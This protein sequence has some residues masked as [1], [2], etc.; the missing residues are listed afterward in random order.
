MTGSFSDLMSIVMNSPAAAVHHHRRLPFTTSPEDTVGSWGEHGHFLDDGRYE[1]LEPGTPRPWQNILSNDDYMLSISQLGTGFSTYKSIFSNRVTRS[2]QEMEFDDK[3]SGRFFYI[4]NHA[5]GDVFS[6]M[7]YPVQTTLEGYSDYSCVYEP[8]LTRW[9]A[10]R[11]GIGMELEALV[12]QGEDTELFRLTLTDFDGRAR[13]LDAF[14]YLEWCFTGAPEDQG[15]GLD[16]GFDSEGNHL[17][18]NVKTHPSRRYHQTGFVTAS[19]PILDYDCRRLAFEGPLGS[20]HCP[21]AVRLGRCRN[22]GAPILGTTTGAV[23]VSVDIPANGSAVVLF[24]VGVTADLGG[25]AERASRLQSAGR[26]ENEKQM[27]TAFWQGIT[28]RQQITIPGEHRDI[29]LF[30]D[31]W[32]KCQV[33]QNARW[34]RW[35][36]KKGY[37]DVLQDAAGARLL[38]PAR[39]R[40][41]ILAA[42]SHLRTDGHAPRN[43]DEAPWKAHVWIDARDCPYWLI[44]SIDAYL[45]ETGDFALLDEMCP[46]I[47]SESKATV[48]DHLLL[49]V[50]FLWKSRGERGLSLFGDC[51][52]NDSLNTP[53]IEGKGESVWLTQAVAQGMLLMEGITQASGYSAGGVNFLERHA[54]LAKALEVHGWDG[55]WFRRGYAD[56]GMLI[57]SSQSEGGGEIYLLPQAWAT[58][59]KTTTPERESEA[60]ASAVK[61]LST[62]FGPMLYT[63]GYASY[64]PSIGRISVSASETNAVYVHASL[65]KA[66]ADLMRGDADS[67]WETIHKVLPA[68][69]ELPSA[70]SGAEPFTCINAIAGA[71]WSWPGWSYT[72][73]WSASPAWLLQILVEWICGA[74]AEFGGLRV[75]PCLP[76]GWAGA[77]IVRHFRGA[78]YHIK[79]SKPEGAKSGAATLV[80][81]GVPFAGNLIPG[82]PAGSIVHVECT[83]APRK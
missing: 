51:D 45:R 36:S 31:S 54:E 38:D 47:D 79:I 12:C 32:L 52:W 2:Y 75:A 67:A 21:D 60:L 49:V 33:I 82:A 83:I 35:G 16:A 9:K 58:I 65:F 68:S 78:E 40:R 76:S 77:S 25:I 17:W 30:F 63:P 15:F 48:W 27:V 73:W 71:G 74:R 80:V 13:D 56:N 34:T 53:G 44:Y 26:F 18:A 61:R 43:W 64:N 50:D 28:S 7:I 14:F 19:E 57:G 62:V 59:S 29:G 81:D 69:G 8:G 39:A 22:S 70:Q 5:D 72:G 3:R 37:R 66:Q 20:I 23:R 6:P 10:T 42:A 46:F 4:R 24:S 11:G 1:L 41:M 55:A